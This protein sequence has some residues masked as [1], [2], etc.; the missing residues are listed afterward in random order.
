MHAGSEREAAGEERLVEH[1]R[2]AV[3]RAHQRLVELRVHEARAACVA[4]AASEVAHVW[5][6]R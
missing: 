5:L 1:R 4:R 3:E 6:L 2:Q